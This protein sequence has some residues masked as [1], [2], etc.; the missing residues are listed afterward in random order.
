MPHGEERALARVSNRGHVMPSFETALSR[1]LGC[2]C[3]E[4]PRTITRREPELAQGFGF[5]FL[6][7]RK[8]SALKIGF[9]GL[10]QPRL[11]IVVVGGG[12]C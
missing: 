7:Q 3:D 9:A 6:Q 1:L 12:K 4:F 11:R 2:R 5:V 8:F 10:S